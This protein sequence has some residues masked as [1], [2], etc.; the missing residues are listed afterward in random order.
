MAEEGIEATIPGL[1][2]RAAQRGNQV[3]LGTIAKTPG[4]DVNQVDHM[5]NTAL[6]Y[7]AGAGHTAT[8]KCLIDLK[9]NVNATN[10]VGDTP[11][12]KASW[13]N[14]LTV[15]QLLVGSGANVTQRNAEGQRPIDL[16]R[17][18]DVRSELSPALDSDLCDDEEDEEDEE[19]SND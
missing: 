6:H 3:E 19:D 18:G 10:N 7:A 1:W 8:V 13:R 16:A 2:Y 15:V 14:A 4:W 17:D 11:L 9:A 5:G 12:H